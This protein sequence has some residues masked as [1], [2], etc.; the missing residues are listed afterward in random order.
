LSRAR[1]R[2]LMALTRPWANSVVYIARK[3]TG[4]R[5]SSDIRF[6]LSLINPTIYIDPR[7][8]ERITSLAIKPRGRGGCPYFLS[9]DWYKTA[10]TAAERFSRDPKYKTA[11]EIILHNWPLEMTSETKWVEEKIQESGNYRGYRSAVQFVANVRDLYTSLGEN[12]YRR[13]MVERFNPWVG[14]IE[15]VVGPNYELIKFNAGN[16]RFA[17]AYVIGLSSIPVRICAVHE[18]YKEEEVDS[19]AIIKKI[20]SAVEDKYR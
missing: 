6:P 17:G 19:I 11:E 4:R 16:H 20:Q 3:M 14:G 15:C 18:S 8:V 1:I 7:K 2:W 10:E 9:G 13:T 12:G 5:N